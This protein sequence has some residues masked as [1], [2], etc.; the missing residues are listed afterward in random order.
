MRNLIRL[1][2]I[3]SLVDER[4]F[5]SVGELSELCQVSEM[6]IRRDLRVLAEQKRIQRTYGGAASVR[7][8]ATSSPDSNSS[9]PEQ[10]PENHWLDRVDVLVA[11]VVNPKFDDLLMESIDKKN[12]PI[13][14]ESL[15]VHKAE[16]VVSVDNY[17]AGFDL[18]CWVGEYAQREWSG[19]AH[20][21]DLTYHLTNT[22]ARSQGFIAGV[23]SILAGANVVLSLNAQS[24]YPTAYQ[25][26]RDALAVHK[27]INIIFA[28]NDTTAWGAI[29]ACK[30]L[31]IDPGQIIVLPFGLEGD[32][33]K[34]AIMEGAYCPAGLAMFPEIA[35]PVCVEAAIAV[36]NQEPVGRQ[37]VIPHLILTPETLPQ[38]YARVGSGWQINLAVVKHKL[39]LPIDL[40]TAGNRPHKTLPGRIGLIV[41]FSQ[42]EWYQNLILFMQRYAQRFGIE[43]ENVDARQSL[44][45]EIDLRR[46]D[47]ARLAAEQ[48][49]PGEVVLID[50]GPIANFLAEELKS[51]GSLTIITN[52]LPVFDILRSNPENVLILTGG[53]YRNSTQMLVGPTAEGALSELRADVLFLMVAGIS[54]DFGLSHTNISE[55][56]MK[57][58]MIRS[59]REVI[60]LADHTFFEQES[61]IQMAPLTTVNKLITDDALPASIR[62]ELTKLGIHILLANL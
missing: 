52:S 4:G 53:A 23:R 44:L 45:D 32:T 39:A 51:R 20:I 27:H 8:K 19:E 60:L 7:L 2:Q 25:L 59:A 33:L 43:V 18:G 35:G 12:I 38:I 5:L 9:Q 16:T 14:A 41:P 30:D 22:Q 37:L 57:Q 29:N 3:V 26:T 11:T 24:R 42:H 10:R 58:A 13:I 34:N 48:V 1:D 40:E 55:V 31:G 28:I 36:Y 15:R 50:G 56:T 54:L 46:R 21:L 61:T 49:H 6:T 17:Q 47:I 62:L